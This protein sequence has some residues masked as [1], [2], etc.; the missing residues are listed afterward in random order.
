MLCDTKSIIPAVVRPSDLSVLCFILQLDVIIA[1]LDGGTIKIPECIHLSLLPEPLLHQTQTSLSL[2]NTNTDHRHTTEDALYTDK[3]NNTRN[4]SYCSKT[5][6]GASVMT[7]VYTFTFKRHQYVSQ[8][9]CKPCHHWFKPK[10][11]RHQLTY[12]FVCFEWFL[13]FI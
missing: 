10:T 6:V 8:L 1:D 5:S 4:Y 11:K 12:C 2:V 7:Q 13:M 3:Y 9:C